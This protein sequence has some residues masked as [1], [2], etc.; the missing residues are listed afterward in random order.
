MIGIGGKTSQR[1]RL[2]RRSLLTIQVG[3][4]LEV[5]KVDDKSRTNVYRSG[6]RLIYATPPPP[7]FIN[8]VRGLC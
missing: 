2:S 5:N 1:T 7:E 3:L 8:R 6:G 4:L